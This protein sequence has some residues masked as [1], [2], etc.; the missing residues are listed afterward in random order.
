[1]SVR[2]PYIFIS[3]SSKNN[4]MASKI[5]AGLREAGFNVWLDLDSIPDGSR[6]LAEIQQGV[7]NCGAILI[8]MSHP[9]RGSQWV[10][11][12]ALLAMELRKP[13]FIALIEDVPLPLHLIDRQF[14]DFR[15][16]FDAPLNALVEA[17][18]DI[19]LM[20]E[21]GKSE[22]LP[23]PPDV[24]PKPTEDNFFPYLQQLPDGEQMAMVASDL[25]HWAKKQAD[26]VE[27][28]GKQKPGFHARL[29]LDEL[30]VTVFTV[31]AYSREPVAEIPFEHLMNYPPYDQRELR[32]STL[33]LLNELLPDD[34]A[35]VE[36]RAD[37]RPSLPLRTA[38]HSSEKLESFKLVVKDIMDHLRRH[39]S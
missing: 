30:Y 35:F 11:R 10:E 15:E 36:D 23:L 14:T 5:T 27:F 16:A 12:E 26:M 25:Y 38:L 19:E 6:W 7:E 8:V 18:R 28:S 17:L 37:R 3:H 9:A 22:R 21:T 34:K 13:L 39:S 33:Q 32:L 31:R 20:D 29:N 2:Q 1:M 24:S 4:E